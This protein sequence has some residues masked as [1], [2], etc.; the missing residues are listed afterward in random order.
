MPACR[1]FCSAHAGQVSLEQPQ[2][3]D[4]PAPNNRSLIFHI[5]VPRVTDLL[6]TPVLA[7]ASGF[8]GPAGTIFKSSAHAA[9]RKTRL[10]LQSDGCSR[11][12][13]LLEKSIQDN[14]GVCKHPALL[15]AEAVD[16]PTA[17]IF[18]SA[19]PRS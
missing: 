18:A 17:G 12:H 15:S 7:K 5:A 4:R 10:K 2:Y 6:S 13:G 3:H 16:P 19:I 1:T 11:H 8:G 9:L 14:L